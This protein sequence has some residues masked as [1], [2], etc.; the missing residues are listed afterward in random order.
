MNQKQL[1]QLL[2]QQVMAG[3]MGA[4]EREFQEQPAAYR[5]FSASEL[6]CPQCKKAMA[7]REKLLLALPNGD[8]YDYLCSGCGNSLGTRTAE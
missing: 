4:T 1:E 6:Y 7:V 3:A 2:A 5:R 8:L